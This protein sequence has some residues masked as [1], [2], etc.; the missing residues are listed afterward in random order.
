LKPK[1]PKSIRNIYGT[2]YYQTIVPELIVPNYMDY[3]HNT[4]F[5][6]LASNVT[7]G[8][9]GFR[10]LLF[11][12]VLDLIQVPWQKGTGGNIGIFYK[13]DEGGFDPSTVNIS[14]HIFFPMTV[15]HD[16]RISESLRFEI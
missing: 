12:L 8:K 2:G 13:R 14:P 15:N 5:C 3:H 4:S 9:L 10:N 16:L 6:Y 1:N 11:N 7:Y